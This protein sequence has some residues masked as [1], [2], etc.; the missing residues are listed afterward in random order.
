VIVPQTELDLIIGK[1]KRRSMWLPVERGSQGERKPCRFEVGQCVPLQVRPGTKST[2][3]TVTEF[4]LTTLAMMTDSDASAQGYLGGLRGARV[5]WERAYG[6]WRADRE[7][8]AVRFILGDHSA[9][10]AQHAER[11]LTRKMGGGRS[12]TTDPARAARG[13]G[14]VPSFEQMQYAAAA[15]DRRQMEARKAL[16]RFLRVMRAEEALLAPHQGSYSEEQKLALDRLRRR[17]G[18]I[19]KHLDSDIVPV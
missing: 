1:R 17:I 18:S 15:A 2:R 8:W 6:P 19:E 3:I 11:Y 10:Y 5:A 14:A 9:L 4:S 16:E 12:L 13:E 7:A